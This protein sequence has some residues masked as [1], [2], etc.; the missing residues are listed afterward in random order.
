M[1]T[2]DDVLKISVIQNKGRSI[3]NYEQVK[4]ICDKKILEKA[5]VFTT[6]RS[7]YE[8]NVFKPL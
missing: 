7:K 1:L 2:K 3:S 8:K 5:S 4:V 6:R